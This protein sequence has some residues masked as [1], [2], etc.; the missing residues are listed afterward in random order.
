MI[1]DWKYANHPQVR[2]GV[3]IFYAYDSIFCFV[4]KTMSFSIF[5]QDFRNFLL[6]SL[7]ILKKVIFG[8]FSFMISVFS[9]WIWHLDLSFSVPS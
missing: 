3:N 5:F 6:P 7:T 4:N 2:N 9:S 8:V 1:D